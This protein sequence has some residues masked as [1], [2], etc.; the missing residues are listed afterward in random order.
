MRRI[1]KV[2][3]ATALMVVLMATTVSPAFAA[4]KNE[5]VLPGNPDKT[6]ENGEG[7]GSEYGCIQHGGNHVN[8]G[9]HAGASK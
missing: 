3:A 9:W 2:L 1:I 8:C 4:P 7:F 5:R 6:G